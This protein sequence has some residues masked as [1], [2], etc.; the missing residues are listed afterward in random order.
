MVADLPSHRTPEWFNPN[1]ETW[2]QQE[3]LRRMAAAFEPPAMPYIQAATCLVLDYFALLAANFGDQADAW[4]QG[5]INL[6]GQIEQEMELIVERTDE[7]NEF[8]D[9]DR[10]LPNPGR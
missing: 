10:R 1:T 8:P 4:D 5:F 3:R 2:A 7:W 6:R 9:S